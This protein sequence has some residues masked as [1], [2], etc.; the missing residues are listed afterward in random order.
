[1]NNIYENFKTNIF[2]KF[3][4]TCTHFNTATFPNLDTFLAWNDPHIYSAQTKFAKVMFS[5]VSVCPQGG[6][7]GQVPP[8]RYTLLRHVHT[9]GAVHA[10]RYGQQAGGTHPTGMHSCPFCIWATRSFISSCDGTWC[11]DFVDQPEL[12]NISVHASCH[13]PVMSSSN[14]YR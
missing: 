7:P 13:E 11:Q 12:N 3:Q 1:M 2:L 10:G 5:H 9:P 14:I 6:V 8:G 4:P